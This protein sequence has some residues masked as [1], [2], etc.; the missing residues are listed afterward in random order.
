MD[1]SAERG[2]GSAKLFENG[3]LLLYSFD[4]SDPDSPKAVYGTPNVHR[5]LGYRPEEIVEGK[6]TLR[7]IL[8]PEDHEI[9]LER[10]RMLEERRDIDSLSHDYRVIKKNGELCYMRAYTSV[11]RDETGK[12]RFYHGYLTNI[13][14]EEIYKKQLENVIEGSRLGYWIW[15]LK[16]DF[17]EVNDFWLAM[18]GLT[19]SD[20]RNSIEDWRERVHPEDLSHILPLVERSI[21]EETLFTAEFR[22]RH[23]DGSWIWVQSSGGVVERSP[24]DGKPL[25]MSGTHQEIGHRKR[26]EERIS[27][28]AFHDTLTNLPN[29]TLLFDR[30]EQAV[31]HAGRHGKVGALLFIDLDNFKHINDT[32]GHKTGDRLLKRIAGRLRKC[33]R[34]EDTVARFGGDEFVVLLTDL[35]PGR[36][37]EFALFVAGKIVEKVSRPIKVKNFSLHTNASVG[38][39]IFPYSDNL[40]KSDPAE[41][42]KRADAAMYHA[43]NEGKGT[44]RFFD[45]LLDEKAQRRMALDS[46]MRKALETGGF[47]LHY[48]PIV[49]IDSGEVT[50]LEALIRWKSNGESQ[51]PA[52]FIPVA[53]ENSL[54][55]EISEF[56]L[57]SVCRDLENGAILRAFPKL[58]SVCVNLSINLF[59]LAEFE[60]RVVRL[61]RKRSVDP[62]WF[63]FELTEKVFIRDFRNI[64][65]KIDALRRRGIRFA[66]DDFG[67]GFASLTSLKRLPVDYIKI[68]KSFIRR[69]DEERDNAKI[70]ETIVNLSDHFGFQVVAEGVETEGEFGFL[71]KISCRYAQGYF[72]SEPGSI[73]TFFNDGS[74]GG[75]DGALQQ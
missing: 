35:D 25:L 18:L 67:T 40:S 42:V 36:A 2:N 48:Q 53:E 46:G 32:L 10:I 52:D 16:S 33:V 26:A 59:R 68:D 21:E 15:N 4:I 17:H 71:K 30:I 29:R 55:V 34:S 9:L 5:H 28:M 56:V 45:R 23:S 74:K 61:M 65:E 22:M 51:R 70:M 20:I 8:H 60:E 12:A 31:R 37:D 64:S 3:P 13:H 58:E 63:T 73:E 57:E 47:E 1:V 72:I 38:I 27:H 50:G 44:I 54:I 41:I 62:S 24:E 39:T 14:E 75:T 19:R 11:E 7:Q 43:K 49:E 66:I 6:V 69:V